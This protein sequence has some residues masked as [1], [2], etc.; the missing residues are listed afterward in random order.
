VYIF[1]WKKVS[2]NSVKLRESISPI[3]KNTWIINCDE[4]YPLDASI[5][6]I[7]LD[8]SHYY[9]SQYNTAIKH[10]K[11][12]AI[13][14]VIVGDNVADNNF[15]VM[16]NTAVNTFN[17]YAV[18]VYAPHDKRS[19]HKS[20]LER[21][22]DDLFNVENTDCGFWFIHPSIV[23]RIRGIDYTSSKSGWGID[24]ITIKE[25]RRQGR[26]VIRDY[27]IQT[28]QLD[29]TCGYNTKR[30]GADMRRLN[31]LYESFIRRDPPMPATV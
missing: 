5:P 1:N 31:A 2:A 21:I 17:K 10:V 8:D 15:N 13:F 29:H 19:S 26:L 7:Q 22:K 27:S 6:H 4:N 30:A 23:S 28:D 18:G 14:C 25:A 16:F 11:E 24:I 12:G 3:I 20:K 9:G